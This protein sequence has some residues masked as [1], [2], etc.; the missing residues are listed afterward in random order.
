MSGRPVITLFSLCA[1]GFSTLL[2][3]AEGLIAGVKIC[4]AVPNVSH[5][6]FAIRTG[7][8]GGKWSDRTAPPDL[9]APS[10][11]YMYTY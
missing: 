9:K 3:K 11:V 8:G 7:L 2:N 5:L 1:E 6:L 10:Q 4:R